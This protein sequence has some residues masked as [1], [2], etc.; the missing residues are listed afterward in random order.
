MRI[1][2][3]KNNLLTIF[4][5]NIPQT[6][7][8]TYHVGGYLFSDFD[9][10][11]VVLHKK[12]W[13]IISLKNLGDNMSVVYIKNLEFR[14]HSSEVKKNGINESLKLFQ[15]FDEETGKKYY[16]IP[17]RGDTQQQEKNALLKKLWTKYSIEKTVKGMM[18][19]GIEGESTVESTE[20][21][22]GYLFGLMILYGKWEGKNKELTS[23][24]IQIPLSGQHL[25]H[26]EILDTIIKRLQQE[27][28]FL[29]T[30]KLQNKNGMV[31]QISSNDYEL[32]EIFAKWYEAVEKFNKI[33][34]R[35]FTQEMKTK[36]MEFISTNPEVP[37]EGKTEV[38]KQ[39]E[40]WTIKL[41]TK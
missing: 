37:Q 2:K 5:E 34:K 6:K 16:F 24:K 38:L 26:A 36:L 25:A 7:E 27:S 11:I 41:L 1:E 12:E 21:M 17:W 22:I 31:Y 32:L 23:I 35:E 40:E 4:N 10:G 20:E 33:T 14:I 39:I 19:K 29:K 8:Y 30:D 3:D 13:R 28:I 18:V 9:K 15:W